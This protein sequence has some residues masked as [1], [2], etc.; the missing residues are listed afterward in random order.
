MKL[1]I[2]DGK[3]GKAPGPDDIPN[4]LFK[5]LATGTLEALVSMFNDI[6]MDPEHKIPASWKQSNV[7]L[8][9]KGPIPSSPLDYRPISLISHSAKLMEVIIH[10]RLKDLKVN[11]LIH[12]NQSGFRPGR[13]TLDQ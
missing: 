12:E 2:S 7:V 9:P 6:L 10:N 11:S 5:L 13:S 8:I 4:D 1:A 3:N